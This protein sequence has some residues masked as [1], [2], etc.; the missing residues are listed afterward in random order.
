MRVPPVGHK[1]LQVP[2]P[3]PTPVPVQS[4][5]ARPE[6][7]LGLAHGQR[8]VRG[9]GGE[10]LETKLEAPLCLPAGAS[11]VGWRAVVKPY[12]VLGMEGWV[13]HEGAAGECIRNNKT[14]D[15]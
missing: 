8:W 5:H 14:L 9:Q 2:V 4:P 7:L 10:S 15:L 3:H 12:S 13:G 6:L 1:S 11:G